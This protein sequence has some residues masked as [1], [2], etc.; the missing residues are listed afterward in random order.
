MDRPLVLVVRETPSLA[1]SL[2]LLLDTV[3]FRVRS[4]PKITPDTPPVDG[5]PHEPPQAIV[6]ASNK[7]RSESLLDFPD[8]FPC[9]LRDLPLVVVGGRAAEARGHWPANV[10]FVGLPIEPRS[11]VKLLS[12]LT[13]TEIMGSHE[14][15]AVEH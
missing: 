8:Q 10:H 3:G 1:D 14:P 4:E 12:D 9:G 5:E 15:L 7:P 2:E 11:F 13:D 6:L